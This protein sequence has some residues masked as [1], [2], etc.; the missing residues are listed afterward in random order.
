M[1]IVH[2]AISPLKKNL[3]SQI[4]RI[5]PEMSY[6]NRRKKNLSETNYA[7]QRP[8]AET[9]MFM[10]LANHS[11]PKEFQTVISISNFLIDFKIDKTLGNFYFKS[12]IQKPSKI[13]HQKGA[14]KSSINTQNDPKSLSENPKFKRTKL[15]SPI[16]ENLKLSPLASNKIQ[17]QKTIDNIKFIESNANLNI[18]IK[19]VG[20]WPSSP[21]FYQFALPIYPF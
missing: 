15:F 18:P 21:K 7:G 14:S 5:K 2:I 6:H 11:K 13:K 12:K 16:N 4:K 17:F 8:V 19:D 3:L 20:K 10:N 1:L 9:G